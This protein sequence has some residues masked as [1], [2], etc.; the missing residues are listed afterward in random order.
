MDKINYSVGAS[1][2]GGSLADVPKSAL[3]AGFTTTT[4]AP[5]DP[6]D[7]EY[8]RVDDGGTNSV[9][10]RYEFS[11]TGACGRPNGNER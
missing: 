7:P 6:W 11:K 10:D 3:S 1:D 4:N 2:I 9:G 8:V 5:L